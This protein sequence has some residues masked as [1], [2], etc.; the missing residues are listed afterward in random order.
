MKTLSFRAQGKDKDKEANGGYVRTR[1][2]L[3]KK[4][5]ILIRTFEAK[6]RRGVRYPESHFEIW[7][8]PSD[9]II[10]QVWKDNNGCHLYG[11]KQYGITFDDLEV[12]L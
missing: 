4:D 3:D 7:A 10:L 5:Y 12:T 9:T 8:S 1:A 6:A 11:S 2:I